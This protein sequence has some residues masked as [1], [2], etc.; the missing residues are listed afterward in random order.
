MIHCCNEPQD[1]P[2]RSVIKLPPRRLREKI[3][4]RSDASEYL[5][6]GVRSA[7]TIFHVLRSN[8]YDLSS[9]RRILDFACGCGRT[10][11]FMRGYVQGDRLYGCDREADL[12][13]WCQKNLEAREC[14]V[15]K[16]CRTPFPDAYFDFIYSLAFF[17]H[18][19]EEMQKKWLEEWR[20]IIK[21]DGL[22][23]VSLRGP[24]AAM[25]RGVRIPSRGFVHVNSGRGFNERE[26]FQ[27]REYVEL[28]WT[29]GFEILDFQD[30]GLLN[31][32]D[33]VLLGTPKSKLH[34]RQIPPLRFPLDLIQEYEQRPALRFVFDKNGLGRPHRGWRNLSLRDWALTN[35]GYDVPQLRDMSFKALYRVEGYQ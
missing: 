9:F 24:M 2:Y 12:V 28:E 30:Q 25:H 20:R 8:G 32:H 14:V 16:T 26:S 13:A 27:T 10:L 29:R 33:L 4:S 21:D 6:V 5:T 23:L 1:A 15:N 17:T 22:I 34:R 18:L 3:S 7:S 11:N 19:T 35:G 31:S